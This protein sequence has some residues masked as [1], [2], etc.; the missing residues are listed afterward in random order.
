[1]TISAF[2]G[3]SVVSIELLRRAKGDR[4]LRILVIGGTRFIGPDVVT[5]LR[6]MGHEIALFHRGQTRADV[7]P[8]VGHILGDRR[9]LQDFADEFKRFAPQVV[10]DMIPVTE[11][12]AQTVVATF[13]GIAQRVI[14]ISSQ[15]VYRAYGK[16]IRIESGPAE[17]IPLTEDAPLRQ[18][19]YPYRD[20][21]PRD[22]DDP[23]RW[24]DD[25][26]KIL[27]ERVIM[28]NA[29][30]PGTI[31]RLPMVYGPR[32]GQHR[33][34]DYL[35]RMDD[36]RPAVLLDEGMAGWRWTRG[37]V[38]NVA[39]AIALA[40]TDE[41]SLGR[42]YNVGEVEAFTVAEW[43]RKIGQAAQWNGKVVVVPQDRLPTHLT[44]DI[45]TAQHLVVDTCRIRKE[46]G[47]NE[48]VLQDEALRRTIAWERAH[49]PD[50]IDPKQ[51]DY[52]AEDTALAELGQ[53]DS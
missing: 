49:P 39:A 3:T 47:Y 12:D 33:L 45:N 44:P 41:R 42:I 40:V 43:V 9:Q 17:P 26:D 22:Q 28:G 34:F 36:S 32:D 23:K 20:N 48:P 7:L 4:D 14:A 2:C 31:L 38:T 10:L 27:V 8:G 51:F 37:Y 11:Q 19:L 15:D 35:K 53:R 25:Y 13:K 50:R 46:L 52:A 5:H 29:D 24:M 30:L 6:A 1:L 16:L 18:R 21:T